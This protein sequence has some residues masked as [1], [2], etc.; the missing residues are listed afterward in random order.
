MQL[1]QISS[2]HLRSN[3]I[4][5]L[6]PL[7]CYLAEFKPHFEPAYIFGWKHVGQIP[8]QI[9]SLRRSVFAQEFNP[10]S[11]PLSPCILPSL[12]SEQYITLV[13]NWVKVS[14]DEQLPSHLCT[15]SF[16]PLYCGPSG[17]CYV[18]AR[19]RRRWWLHTHQPVPRSGSRITQGQ[20]QH[21]QT[22]IIQNGTVHF[23]INVY[24]RIRRKA[25]EVQ[26][27]ILW[28]QG[29]LRRRRRRMEW[30]CTIEQNLIL[31]PKLLLHL[32][33]A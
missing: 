12:P 23:P 27:L 30:D 6:T 18:R 10:H 32:L 24:I 1:L 21:F 9:L 16:S 15:S 29:G 2:V 22:E 11:T 19:R 25:K 33:L 8:S 14:E 4:S 31:S 5:E 13:E 17:R 7:W 28:Y 26:E 3:Y 20:E